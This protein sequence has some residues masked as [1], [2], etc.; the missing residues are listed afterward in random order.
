MA[1]VIRLDMVLLKRNMSLT[2]LQEKM[3]LAYNNLSIIKTQKARAIRLTTLD[4]LCKILECTPGDLL[5]IMDD[6]EYKKLYGSQDDDDDDE[7]KKSKKRT[8]WKLP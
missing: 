2:E 4:L 6:E 1:I 7:K 8:W 3:G 5:E